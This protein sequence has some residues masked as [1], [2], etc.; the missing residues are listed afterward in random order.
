MGVVILV[1]SYVTARNERQVIDSKFMKK[2]EIYKEILHKIAITA[3]CMKKVF[4]TKKNL[5]ILP[6]TIRNF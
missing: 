2:K 6:I 5:Q 3:R 4:A 1:F